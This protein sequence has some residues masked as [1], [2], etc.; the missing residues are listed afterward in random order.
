M[1]F[2]LNV[3]FYFALLTS[4]CSFLLITFAFVSL[5]AQVAHNNKDYLHLVQQ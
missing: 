1:H 3:L 5:I 4:V 2:N